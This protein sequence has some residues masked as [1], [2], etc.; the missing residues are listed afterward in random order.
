MSTMSA[1]P[2]A[3]PAATVPTPSSATS[4][5]E[6]RAFGLAFRVD[7]ELNEKYLSYDID[8]ERASG[9]DHHV[10]PAPA[11]YIIGTDGVINFAYINPDYKVRL[12]PDVLLAAAKAYNEEADGRLVLKRKQARKQ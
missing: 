12:H 11:T 3:T 5:T 7:D 1:L 8:L 2:F 6:I 10:L 9:E 4:F